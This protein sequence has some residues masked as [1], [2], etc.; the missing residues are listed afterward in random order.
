MSNDAQQ[1]V[2]AK[3]KFI[4]IMIVNYGHN[5]QQWIKV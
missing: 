5:K 2:T 1:L 4:F 3:T